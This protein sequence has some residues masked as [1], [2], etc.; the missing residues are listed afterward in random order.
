MTIKPFA[1]PTYT[2]VSNAAL[3]HVMP[4]VSPALWKVICAVIRKT[5]GFQKE[6]DEI[7]LT[8]LEK[9]TGLSRPTVSQCAQEGLEMGILL[10]K[11]K[12]QGYRYS[13]NNQYEIFT[14]KESLLVKESNQ[15]SK[16]S[17][18]EV[19]K[20]LYTQKKE[21]NSK[22]NYAPSAQERL[23]N[24]RQK[25]DPMGMGF[26][27]KP[28]TN[29]LPDLSWVPE[30]YLDY[31]RTFVTDT[32][33]RPVKKDERFW[34]AAFKDWM[35]R[36][37]TPATISQAIRQMRAEKDPKKRLTISSPK[38]VTNVAIDIHSTGLAAAEDEKPN[39]ALDALRSKK[40]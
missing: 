25:L 10:R 7:S 38:S 21:R 19:V 6:W 14:S 40:D 34:I 15:T 31:A 30:I 12:G 17:L 24:L 2:Q 28:E 8:Q 29:G 36:S 5:K 26:P 27:F 13:I 3:D 4:A 32:G 1:E 39:R 23:D 9:L 20:N 18:P 16:E 11:P 33:I 35:E 22:E 37:L